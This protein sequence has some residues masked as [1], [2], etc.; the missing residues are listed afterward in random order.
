MWCP[1][2]WTATTA[3]ATRRERILSVFAATHSRVDTVAKVA[4]ESGVKRLLLTH[5]NPGEQPARLAAEARAHFG[6]EVIVAE[7]GLSLEL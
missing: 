5:L 2:S 7:D 6:G 1:P 3:D 4:A